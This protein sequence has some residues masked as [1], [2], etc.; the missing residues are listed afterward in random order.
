MLKPVQHDGWQPAPVLETAR[1]RM[2]AFRAD[3]FADQV[4]MLSDPEVMRYLGGSFDRE[5]AWRRSLGG[6]GSWSVLGYGYWVVER[7]ED[8]RMIGHVGFSEPKRDIVPSIEGLPEM[9][10]VFAREVGGQGYASEAVEAGLAWAD[11][12]LPPTEIT[13]IIAPANDRSIRLAGKF[14]FA[15]AEETLY[16]GDP[17]LIFRRPART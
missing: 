14:G 4:R 12:N 8:K 6:V 15:R 2:R 10:W 16:K 17:T 3:D 1:L 11:A 13:A 9:G 5:D 7:R